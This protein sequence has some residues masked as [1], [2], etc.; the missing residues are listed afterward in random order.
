ME[1][2]TTSRAG[3]ATGIAL[4]I[5]Q[6]AAV[7]VGILAATAGVAYLIVAAAGPEVWWP[8]GGS[9]ATGAFVEFPLPLRLVNAGA[10]LIWNATTAAMALFVG[11]LAR[12]IRHAVLF[13]PAVTRAAWSLAIA[14]AVGSTLAQTLENVGRSSAIV[15][16]Y[17]DLTGDP[18]G[19]PIGWGIGWYDLAPNLPLLAVSVVLG[20]LAYVIGAGERLQRDTEGLV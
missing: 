3:R 10:F 6:A 16:A 7:V 8:S 17:T 9:S 12:R 19:A 18:M 5:I 13:V 1:E 14:L 4:R 20:L 11:G 15:Y 2:P